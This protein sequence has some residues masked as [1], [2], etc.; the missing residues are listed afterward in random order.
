[1]PL[2]LA[3]DCLEGLS[4]LN[5]D[6]MLS[7]WFFSSAFELLSG[8]RPGIELL[9]DVI[10]MDSPSIT[11]SIL[12]VIWMDSPSITGSIWL[13]ALQVTRPGIDLLLDVMRMDSPSRK[14]SRWLVAL[15]VT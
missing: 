11:G 4:I 9:L 14:D 12:D 2:P 7:L 15:E 10:W 13:V 1:M 6:I 3:G 5:A 8:V